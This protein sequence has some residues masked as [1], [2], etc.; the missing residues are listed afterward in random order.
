ML[1][2][3]VTIFYIFTFVK[4]IIWLWNHNQQYFRAPL[5]FGTVL[6]K[7]IPNPDK[8]ISKYLF[9]NSINYK[10]IFLFFVSIRGFGFH[11]SVFT[12]SVHDVRYGCHLCT[13][14]IWTAY[15]QHFIIHLF[16]GAGQGWAVVLLFANTTLQFQSITIQTQV[17]CQ[18]L[19]VFIAS[20]LEMQRWQ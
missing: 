6:W 2:S 20:S 14:P 13:L 1:S 8:D 15:H 18:F 4:Q 9:S 3:V 5:F 11:I 7:F 12:V 16:H 19:T 10:N 17:I